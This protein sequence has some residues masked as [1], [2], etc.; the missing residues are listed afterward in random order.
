MFYY[1]LGYDATEEG[2]HGS[3]TAAGE[4]CGLGDDSFIKILLPSHHLQHF[5]YRFFASIWIYS[6]L[7]LIFMECLYGDMELV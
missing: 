7:F 5:L 1:F 6:I 3:D 4:L 2:G